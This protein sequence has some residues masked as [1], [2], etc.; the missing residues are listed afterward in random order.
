MPSPRTPQPHESI[1]RTLSPDHRSV[2][3]L[4]L[5]CQAA[6]DDA[7]ATALLGVA[8]LAEAGELERVNHRLRVEAWAQ[9]GLYLAAGAPSTLARPVEG[10]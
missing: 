5:L 1:R 3:R 2:A 8:A 4:G 6:G 9:R 10:I 7:L